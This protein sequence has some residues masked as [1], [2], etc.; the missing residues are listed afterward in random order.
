MEGNRVKSTEPT[1]AR[2]EMFG[3]L[4]G[5]CPVVDEFDVNGTGSW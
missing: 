5:R 2:R 4:G 1:D 3:G